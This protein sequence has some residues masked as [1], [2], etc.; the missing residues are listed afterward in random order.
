MSNQILDSFSNRLTSEVLR[1]VKKAPKRTKTDKKEC[2][3]IAG[4]DPTPVIG[5]I[6]D[7]QRSTF[8]GGDSW[9]RSGATPKHCRRVTPKRDRYS[10]Q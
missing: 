3:S 4:F 10:K 7:R 5:S 1:S 8:S 2:L 6:Q 9:R